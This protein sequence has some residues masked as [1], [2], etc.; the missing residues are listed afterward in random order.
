MAEELSKSE[1]LK[2]MLEQPIDKEKARQ[3]LLHLY[4]LGENAPPVDKER[5]RQQL[6]RMREITKTMPSIDIV[7]FMRE[8]RRSRRKGGK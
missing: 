8:R 5:V 7:A 4:E 1:E 6:L 2:K 3:A